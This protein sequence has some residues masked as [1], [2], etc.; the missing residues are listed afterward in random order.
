M[1]GLNTVVI[2]NTCEDSL[3]ATP[4]IIDLVLLAEL[5]E[6]VKFKI[7]SDKSND[8]D[9]QSFNSVLSL[10]SYLLKCPLVERNANA[11]N[12]LFKQRYYIENTLRALLSLPPINFM[13][14][15][16]KLSDDS[17]WFEK[18]TEPIM[19]LIMNGI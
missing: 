1:G 4:L 11:V 7:H 2:H 17:K 19:N 14:F 18:E 15:K 13:D 6:R 5:C 9:F 10:L 12:S 16:Y 8:D 3:L